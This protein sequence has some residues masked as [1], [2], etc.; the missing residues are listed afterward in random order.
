MASDDDAAARSTYTATT[1]FSDIRRFT[2]L[3]E[4]LTAQAT[5]DLL[6]EYFGEMAELVLEAGGAVDKYIG[7]GL[8]AVFGAPTVGA[9]DADDAARAATRMVARLRHL[10]RAR[11]EHGAQPLE[12]GVGIAS[13]EV[14]AGPVGSAARTDFTVIGNSV[15]LAARLE[16]ANVQYGTT[17]LLAG[18]TV[19]RLV[20]PARLRPIDVVRVKGK[21]I[22]T[23]IFELL[24]HHTPESFPRL[25]EALPL[26]EE[27]VRLYRARDW[28]RALDRF[29]QV[30]KIAPKDGPSWVYI[31][32]C[33]YYRDR[34]PPDYWD[35]VWTMVRK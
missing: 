31:D 18:E 35:G 29:T 12:I 6:N 3:A 27:G 16:S 14:V 7:D 34:P 1:L 5:V 4:K 10:N 25:D 13:G 23:E 33:L 24:D 20:A 17:I 11:V 15:N 8:M 22:A 9:A 2:T 21:R 30:L 32:R 19:R 28:M 26:F